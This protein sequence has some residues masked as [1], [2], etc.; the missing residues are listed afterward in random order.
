M[1][2]HTFAANDKTNQAVDAIK[3][4]LDNAIADLNTYLDITMKQLDKAFIGGFG[5]LGRKIDQ[6]LDTCDQC[7]KYTNVLMHNIF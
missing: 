6:I 5:I 7:G 4:D 1:I 2:L 3:P